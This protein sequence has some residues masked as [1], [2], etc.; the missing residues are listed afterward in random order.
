MNMSSCTGNN[1]PSQNS[2]LRK[3]LILSL[4][5]FILPNLLFFFIYVEIAFLR[6]NFIIAYFGLGM[7][8][9]LSSRTK[10]ANFVFFLTS[11]L[12]VLFMVIDLT[13]F[14][15]E[16][17]GLHYLELIS[18]AGSMFELSLLS[19][20][21]Y[22][23]AGVIVVLSAVGTI[24]LYRRL[25]KPDLRSFGILSAILIALCSA[26][27]L[28]NGNIIYQDHLGGAIAQYVT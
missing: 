16:F 14:S 11:I 5:T 20:A 22:N 6:T 19:Y 21:K 15:S 7:V 3:L 18:A 23:L 17:F 10:I 9:A 27:F 2:N 25:P 8:V 12:F 4:P 26:E 13:K 24:F 1:R 28:A